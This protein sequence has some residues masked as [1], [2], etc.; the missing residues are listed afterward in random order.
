MTPVAVTACRVYRNPDSKL[1]DGVERPR[2]F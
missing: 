1:D 2:E